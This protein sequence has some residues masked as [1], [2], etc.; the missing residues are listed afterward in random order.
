[1]F[2]QKLCGMYT[3][4]GNFDLKIDEKP[5]RTIPVFQNPENQIVSSTLDGELAFSPECIFPIPSEVTYIV[6]GIKN[7]LDF[8]IDGTRHPVTLSGGEKELLN[9]ATALSVKPGLIIIDDGLSFLNNKAKKDQVKRLDNYIKET[10][11]IIL[12]FTS[13]ISDLK[14]GDSVWELTLDSFIEIT[15]SRSLPKYQRNNYP[16]GKLRLIVDHLTYFYDHK[17]IILN[18]LSIEILET[19]CFGIIGAN[20]SGK[21]TIAGIFSG[22][23]PDYSG[24][25]LLEIDGKSPS[26]GYLNQFPEKMLGTVT[27]GEFLLDL[28]HFGKLNPLLVNQ[29]LNMMNDYQINWN[30][31]ENK[32]AVDVQ[33]TALRLAMIIL[34]G[35]SNYELII[36][37]EP[38]FGLGWRQKQTL[39]CFINKILNKKHC[40]IISHDEQF[41]HS[42]CDKVL[43]LD[44]K[45]IME[46][47]DLVREQR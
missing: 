16:A 14:F 3:E 30:I 35:C 39:A 24:E 42:I 31:I 26:I 6:D 22:I 37:D 10:G 38:T 2:F 36:L 7:K 25:F 1:I 41:I 45:S 23:L 12:W 44:T 8:I 18:D 28:Q 27:L 9:L 13:D 11:S 33:W 17:R 5:T 19:R 40:I 46:N 34:L 43:N 32:P 20:G 29:A 47:P 21:T 4:I 15:K